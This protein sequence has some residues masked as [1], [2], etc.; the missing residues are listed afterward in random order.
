MNWHSGKIMS[1]YFKISQMFS[2]FFSNFRIFFSKI[3]APN[4]GGGPDRVGG[5]GREWL[6]DAIFVLVAYKEK[7]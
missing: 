1:N 2:C 7:L 3:F 6:S 5:T 4:D